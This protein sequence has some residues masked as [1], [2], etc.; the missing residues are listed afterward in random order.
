[1]P[2]TSSYV[3]RQPAKH[4]FTWHCPNDLAIMLDMFCKVNGINKTAWLNEL[5]RTALD[6]K[7]Q[8]LKD[9]K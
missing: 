7:F 5:V 9:Q 8:R 3:D 6:E 2:K 4:G 1:M